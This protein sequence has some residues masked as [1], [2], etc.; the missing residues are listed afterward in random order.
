MSLFCL[1]CLQAVGQLAPQAEV[2]LHTRA[3][4]L[5]LPG[6]SDSS[7]ARLAQ[8][9][10]LWGLAKVAAL[11]AAELQWS[12]SSAL[13][14]QPTESA[15][16]PAQLPFRDVYGPNL[17]AG[18]YLAPR[19]LAA[20]LTQAAGASPAAVGA[21]IVTGGLGSLG[22]LIAAQ[23]LAGSSSQ[24]PQVVLLGR[25]INLL[26][27]EA[28]LGAAWRRASST[29]MPCLTVSQCDSAAAADVAGLAHSMH[30]SGVRIG[31]L[32]HAAG[33]LKVRRL[34]WRVC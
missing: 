32:I 23:Q 2:H 3:S 15:L 17:S 4:P 18:A 6:G 9:H 25:S 20:S 30:S 33:V 19:L 12:H 7:S 5:P 8:Q 21:T 16:A 13:P 22:T 10:M 1:P 27:L 28:S 29:G 34:G 24:Q 31:S 14:Q 26:A 11:D